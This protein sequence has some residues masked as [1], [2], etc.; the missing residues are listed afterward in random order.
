MTIIVVSSTILWIIS[1]WVMQ[2]DGDSKVQAFWISLTGLIIS[3]IILFFR[4]QP[5]F[6]TPLIFFGLIVSFTASIGF[7]TIMM[8][9][10]KIGPVGLT[11]TVNNSMLV[12]GVVYSIIFLNP[13]IPNLIVILGIIG[14][15]SGLII[16]GISTSN[17]SGNSQKISPKWTKLVMIGGGLAGISFMNQAYIGACHPGIDPLM[18]FIFWIS[19]F[20]IAILTVL[21]IYTRSKII[22]KREM[23]GGFLI[24]ILTNVALFLTLYSIKLIGAEIVFPIAVASPMV[25]MLIIGHFLYKEHL[26]LKTGIGALLAIISVILLSI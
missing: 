4:E 12:F 15:I 23:I 3:G 24:G 22:K 19:L 7:L 5:I 11:M 18:V 14:S 13:H 6:I 16:I 1:K 2:G 9:C 26:Q 17:Q 20:S 8:Y 25:I 21:I 10:L